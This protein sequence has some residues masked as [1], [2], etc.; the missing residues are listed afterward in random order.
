MYYG[1]AKVVESASGARMK[2]VIW[3]LDRLVPT[4]LMWPAR[5]F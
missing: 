5:R 3:I 2:V 1:A 4:L